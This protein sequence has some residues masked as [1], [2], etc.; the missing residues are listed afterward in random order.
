MLKKWVITSLSACL[1]CGTVLAAAP[2]ETTAPAGTAA[3]GTAVT[4]PVI[5]EVQTDPAVNMKHPEKYYLVSGST[6][7]KVTGLLEEIAKERTGQPAVRSQYYYRVEKNLTSNYLYSV[8]A[9]AAD[10][11]V[12]IGSYFVAKDGSCVWRL[13]QNGDGAMIFGTADKLLEKAEVVVYPDKIQ[14]GSHGILRVHVPGRLPYDIKVTSLNTS[15][16]SVSDELNIMP[17][18][19]GKT[20]LVIDLKMGDTIRTL[21]KSVRV[22]ETA[23]RH[24]GSSGRNVGVGIGIGVGWGGGWHHHGGIDIWV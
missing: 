3:P 22:V 2:A 13:S 7:E 17:Q 16:A 12:L 6:Y 10:T 5:P 14:M 23:D 9:Y 15:I 24:T 21:T 8:K 4:A 20:D 11:H 18:S 1:L 19:E